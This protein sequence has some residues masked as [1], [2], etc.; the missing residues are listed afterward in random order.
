MVG[1]GSGKWSLASSSSSSS[2][3]E[4]PL[5][6]PSLSPPPPP[7]YHHRPP[8]NTEP[9]SLF[10]EEKKNLKKKKGKLTEEKKKPPPPSHPTRPL[11]EP[12]RLSK[13]G[14]HAPPSASGRLR[15]AERRA[16]GAAVSSGVAP[17]RA[18]WARHGT[19]RPVRLWRKKEKALLRKACDLSSPRPLVTAPAAPPSRAQPGCCHPLAPVAHRRRLL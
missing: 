12:G 17:R 19:P 11:R 16:P 2:A 14:T 7:C 9:A 4:C 3:A 1:A 6:S 10:P 8:P 15:R 5:L 13:G 18:M